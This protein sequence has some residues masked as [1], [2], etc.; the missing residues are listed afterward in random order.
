M[1]DHQEPTPNALAH[2]AVK[3]SDIERVRRDVDE[4]EVRVAQADEA[5]AVG[6]MKRLRDRDTPREPHAQAVTVDGGEDENV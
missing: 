3:T 6:R 1:S 4:C 5:S 2:G